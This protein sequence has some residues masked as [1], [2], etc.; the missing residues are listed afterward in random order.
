MRSLLTIFFI[1]TTLAI[2]AK[3]DKEY[4]LFFAGDV[5]M[6]NQFDKRQS[7]IENDVIFSNISSNYFFNNDIQKLSNTF[8]LCL[9]IASNKL[10]NKHKDFISNILSKSNNNILF[11]GQK[12]FQDFTLATQGDSKYGYISIGNSYKSLQ[13]K[14]SIIIKNII[15]RLKAKTDI[16]IIT[17]NCDSPNFLAKTAEEYLNHIHNFAHYCINS[18]ADIFLVYGNK[19]PM[20]AEIFE[21]RL[22]V[23]GL[24]NS[25]MSVTF[26]DD[27]TFK[28]LNLIQGGK[29]IIS[30]TK[31]FFPNGQLQFET[32]ENILSNNITNIDLVHSLLSHASKFKGKKYCAGSTGPLSFDCSGFTS[33]IYKQFGYSLPHS[34]RDQ[35]SLGK[36]ISKNQLRPGD[37]VFFASTSTKKINHVGI[38]YSVDHANNTFSFIH[39]STTRGVTIDNFS[40]YGYYIKRYVGARRIINE[41]ENNNIF[42]NNQNSYETKI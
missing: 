11:A 9:S 16:T 37:L 2:Y 7:I 42:N 1:L 29:D 4:K 22:I 38:V 23:Y 3:N 27:G 15:S 17:Y 5:N 10:A 32:K 26:Y 8:P 34:S 31:S 12:E 21:D 6:I 24:E 39:A 30:A 13:P 28:N 36:E 18:G 33:F 35:F 41:K 25:A 40:K 14:D 19:Y 20:P